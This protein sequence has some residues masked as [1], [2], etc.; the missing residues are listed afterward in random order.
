MKPARGWT[1]I[2]ARAQYPAMTGVKNI[3]KTHMIPED[4]TLAVG[5]VSDDDNETKDCPGQFSI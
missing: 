5:V 4:L 1:Q 2:S 3:T